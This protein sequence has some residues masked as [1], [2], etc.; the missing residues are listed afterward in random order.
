[1]QTQQSAQKLSK[2]LADS[3]AL[4]LKTHNFHW[5][6]TG[7]NFI[8][9]HTFFETIYTELATAV[10]E[11]AERIRTLGYAAPGS[12]SAFAALTDVKEAPSTPPSADEMIKQLAEA[13][14]VVIKTA[15]EVLEVAE[16]DD[17]TLDL[18]T[19]RIQTHEKTLW[20]LESYAPK[21]LSLA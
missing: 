6:I 4:Y 8:E 7:S 15:R 21:S 17:V 16:G 12:F 10:D 14:K 9:L 3:Y 2:L 13:H 5:N 20:M 19:G 11:I 1:M 18:A